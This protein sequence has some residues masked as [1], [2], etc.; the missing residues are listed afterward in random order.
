MSM[1]PVAS[2]SSPSLE[3]PSSFLAL[4]LTPGS[5][6]P[7]LA[8]HRC[9]Q[10]KSRSRLFAW[11]RAFVLM[12][13]CQAR[14]PLHIDTPALHQCHPPDLRT[15]LSYAPGLEVCSDYRSVCGASALAR[16]CIWSRRRAYP[17]LNFGLSATAPLSGSPVQ[18]QRGMLATGR[19]RAVRTFAA[20]GDADGGRASGL[21][22]GLI[23]AA[24]CPHLE[25]SRVADRDPSM[26]D[27]GGGDGAFFE[28][29]E[30]AESLLRREALPRLRDSRNMSEGSDCIW[31]WLA[32][33]AHGATLGGRAAGVSQRSRV[34][35]GL[36]PWNAARG[37]LRLARI[38]LQA[39]TQAQAA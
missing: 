8:Y 15:T 4:A 1:P 21:D 32:L 23:L 34:A 22:G 24:R 33:G 16:L 27:R 35:R 30:Q 19:G 20:A 28:L 39:Q 2:A 17:E 13:L 18:V 12:L 9:T 29:R 14:C 3:F 7:R 10:A 38:A 36:A 25:E 31:C 6:V 26:W 37:S 5:L 11:P